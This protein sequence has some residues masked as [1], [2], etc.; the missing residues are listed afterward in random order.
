MGL[1]ETIVEMICVFLIV[2]CAT[3]LI[4]F[5]LVF[6]N[7]W[8]LAIFF[9]LEIYVWVFF[10]LIGICLIVAGITL[11]WMYYREWKREELRTTRFEALVYGLLSLLA[12]NFVFLTHIFLLP[13]TLEHRNF[14]LDVLIVVEVGLLMILIGVFVSRVRSE[15]YTIVK[16]TN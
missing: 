11:G 1:K 6:D 9:G 13:A 15:A 4:Y 5:G 14:I 3:T 2:A 16:V 8:A 10:M 7:I 12:I